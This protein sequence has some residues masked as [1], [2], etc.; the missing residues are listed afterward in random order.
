MTP[1]SNLANLIV[2]RD[3]KRLDWGVLLALGI[4]PGS[5]F[6]AKAFGE[7]CVRMSGAQVIQ[8]SITGGVLMGTGTV[9][10]GGC[11]IGNVLVQISL[12]SW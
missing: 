11:P 1:S 8:R 9:W 12:L 4:L 2:V 7:F 3:V 5:Y 10:A 6:T